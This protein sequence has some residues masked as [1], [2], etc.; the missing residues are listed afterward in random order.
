MRAWLSTSTLPEKNKTKQKKHH[1]TQDEV[2]IQMQ[3]V[4]TD[5]ILFISTRV[6]LKSMKS[7]SY[8]HPSTTSDYEDATPSIF[9]LQ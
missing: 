3:L 2:V 1:K 9:F 6:W 8:N 4:G 7:S 5:I